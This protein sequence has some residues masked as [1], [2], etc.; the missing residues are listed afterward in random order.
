MTCSGFLGFFLRK[1]FCILR[2]FRVFFWFQ[3]SLEKI[4]KG[5]EDGEMLFCYHFCFVNLFNFC[6]VA[7]IKSEIT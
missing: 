5:W 6:S 7:K 1:R 4:G 2:G 3:R